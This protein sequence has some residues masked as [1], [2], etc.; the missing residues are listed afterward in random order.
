MIMLEKTVDLITSF[1]LAE[2]EGERRI[3]AESLKK[4][5]ETGCFQVEESNQ[6]S[7]EYLLTEL[8]VPSNLLGHDYI[9]TAVCAILENPSFHKCVCKQLYPTV[10]KVHR[11][12]PTSVER[13]IRHTIEVSFCRGDVETLNKQF[14]YTVSA[15]TGKPT[16]SEFL[17]CLAK[18]VRRRK[19]IS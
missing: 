10:A 3:I 19:S 14:G 6:A 4:L 9:V 15:K 2:D 5:K 7:V 18:E 1:I 8:G 13:A 16:N 17:W 12:T 11:T